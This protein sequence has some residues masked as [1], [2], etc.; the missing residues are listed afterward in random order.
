VTGVA[1]VDRA[2]AG[3]GL[4]G[5]AGPGGQHA[6]E[7][8]DAAA[9]GPDQVGRL[10]HAHEVARPVLGQR[11]GGDVEGGE[12]PLLPLAHRQPADGVALE[13]DVGE[14]GGGFGTEVGVDAALDDAELAIALPVDEGVAR[15]L[16][17]G[18]RQPHRAGRHLRLR[19]ERRALV[20]GHGDG[21]VE[22]VLDLGR[23]LRRQPVLAAVEMRAEGHA[24]LVHAPQLGQRHHLE[25]AG[26][27]QDRP[28]PVHEAVQPAQPAHT[29]RPRPQ[30][31]MVGV[32]EH[33]LRAG[34][35][36]VLR[37][38][39][40]HRGGG[41]D[42]HEGRGVDRAMGG[43]NA[44]EAGVSVTAQEFEAE[45]GIGHGAV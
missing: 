43:V 18:H 29:L 4:A 2:A 22:Q 27:G 28:G 36:H 19:R 6:V 32:A 31:Q 13:A 38:H 44:P 42:R 34:R 5:A 24:V 21:G 41:A 17:P 7:H 37:L 25:A 9:H 15:P 20:E 40:L 35:G 1:H 16:R 33:D 3:E 14:G 39:R 11:P 10:A 8:V 26:I 45:G 12:H 23:P 30:H